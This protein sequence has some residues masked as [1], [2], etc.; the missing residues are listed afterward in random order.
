MQKLNKATLKWMLFFGIKYV[1]SCS[2][3]KLLFRHEIGI[4][5]WNWY[6]WHILVIGIDIHV[7]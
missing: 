4:L 2:D 6:N 1:Y 3:Y 7:M 5:R